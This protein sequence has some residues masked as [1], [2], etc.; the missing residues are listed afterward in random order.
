MRTLKPTVLTLTLLLSCLLLKSQNAYYEF[1]T[2]LCYYKCT[3]DSTIYSREQLD[4]TYKYLWFPAYN[5]YDA[6]VW[7]IQDMDTLSIGTNQN[8]CNENLI[9]LEKLPFVDNPYWEKLR[10]NRILEYLSSCR[11]REFTIMAYTNPDTLMYYETVDSTC[12]FYR[13]ALIS[14]GEELLNAW[15]ILINEQKKNNGNPARV[16]TE[17]EEK[18]N[19][20]QKYEYARMEVMMFGWW[21]NANRLI[22]H[23]NN[24]GYMQMEFEKLFRSWE[25]ECDEP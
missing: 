6:T 5:Y 1:N 16:Q 9:K 3:F 11:L 10:Q 12:I 21:N 17:Y 24:D 2:E 19:S 20:E 23:M 13:N 25:V 7:N 15:A 14:G 4:N 8:V 22:Y 18:L